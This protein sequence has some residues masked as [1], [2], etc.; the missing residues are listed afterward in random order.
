[1]MSSVVNVVSCAS[2]RSSV[3]LPLTVQERGL[4]VFLLFTAMTSI[5]LSVFHSFLSGSDKVID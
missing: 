3:A 4:I 2:A 1:M 5:T